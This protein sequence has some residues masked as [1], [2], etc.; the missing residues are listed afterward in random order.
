[1]PT[2]RNR[3]NP[4]D[5]TEHANRANR[6][7]RTSNAIEANAVRRASGQEAEDLAAR[8]LQAR[9]LQL[10]AR[11]VRCRAGE[12]DLVLREGAQIVFVE[13]RLR[14]NAR[15]GGAAYSIDYRKQAKLLATARYWLRGRTEQACRFDVVLMDA[16]QEDRIQWLRNAFG[17]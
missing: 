17:E 1:M 4:T 10:L 5:R 16:A 14:R 13:V 9:G 2:T 3:K 6:P 12:I 11:N 8:Y 7:N 15:Y